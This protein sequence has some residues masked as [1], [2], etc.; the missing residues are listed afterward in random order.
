MEICESQISMVCFVIG[1]S[2]NFIF[3]KLCVILLRKSIRLNI[4]WVKVE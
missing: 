4:W 1:K 3:Y 2:A